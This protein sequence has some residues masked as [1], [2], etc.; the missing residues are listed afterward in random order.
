LQ[1]IDDLAAFVQACRQLQSD[2]TNLRKDLIERIHDHEQTNIQL[3][4]AAKH[5][6][7]EQTD[8]L[9]GMD[10][11]MCLLRQEKEALKEGIE[12]QQFENVTVRDEVEKLETENAKLRHEVDGL[13]R[14]AEG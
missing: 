9:K 1:S 13:N 3:Q 11:E 10:E 2:N 6:R 4:E 14:S 5:Q 7:A 12:D 8:T